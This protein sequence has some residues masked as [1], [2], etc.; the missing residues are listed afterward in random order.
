MW[1][2]ERVLPFLAKRPN[3]DEEDE[4]KEKSPPLAAKITEV[5]S[6]ITREN[7]YLHKCF[8]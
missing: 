3:D 7:L 1:V 4:E 2:A 6:N 8:W 5:S